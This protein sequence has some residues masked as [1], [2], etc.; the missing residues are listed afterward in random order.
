MLTNDQCTGATR[1]RTVFSNH[2]TTSSVTRGEEHQLVQNGGAQTAMQYKV[3]SVY[4][5]KESG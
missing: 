4:C 5:Y 2:L 1:V 3:H